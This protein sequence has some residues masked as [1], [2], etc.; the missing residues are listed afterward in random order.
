METKVKCHGNP[1]QELLLPW[2]LVPGQSAAGGNLKIPAVV[3]RWPL[4][5]P[6]SPD[7]RM[8]SE[9]GLRQ[10]VIKP[11]EVAVAARQTLAPPPR[12]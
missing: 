4:F 11:E 1:I 10:G 12:V 8:A 2:R 5:S 9:K 3:T 7:P 6:R